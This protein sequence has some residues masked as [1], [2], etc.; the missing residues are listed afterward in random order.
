ML[1]RLTAEQVEIQSLAQEVAQRELRPKAPAW[2]RARSL[3]PAIFRRLGELGFLGMRIPE[4]WGGLGLDLPTYLV[5]LEAL[6]WGDPSVALGVAIHSGPVTA[7]LL[8]E[9]SDEQKA[10]WLPAMAR[11]EILGAFALSEAAAGSDARALA[12]CYERTGSGFVV[13]GRKKWV[14]NGGR[15]GLV[16]LFAKDAQGSISAFLVDPRQPGY[17]VGKRE[18]TL[19]FSASETVEVELDELHLEPGALL[20]GEGLGFRYAQKALDVGRLG[21]AALALGISRAAMEHALAYAGQR[22]QFGQPL[23]HFQATRFKLAEMALRLARG[24]SLLQVAAEAVERE[25]ETG[26]PTSPLPFSARSL[27]AMAKTTAS[28]DAVWIADEA[29]QIF[30]GYGYMRD[31][32]VERLLR[33]AKGTEIFE[34]SNEILRLVI[35]REVSGKGEG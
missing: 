11:G 17:R 33:D 2:D 7:L 18:T 12:T 1:P 30:G 27:A 16:V 32:P 15:A 21:V 29:V 9:G 10:R 26:P 5:A 24:W 35:A 19:G 28:E 8:Q 22:V 4:A 34:G 23:L 25:G 3:D 13:R 20:G 6:A 14:T 31:F